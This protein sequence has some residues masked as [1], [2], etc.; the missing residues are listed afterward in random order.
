MTN[1][2]T[3]NPATPAELF[4]R[5]YAQLK[6]VASEQMK[7]ERAGHTLQA[8][9]LVNEAYLR[10]SGPGAPP[11]SSRAAFFH[12]AAEAMRRILIEHARSRGAAKRG[13]GARR[14]PADVLDLAAEQDPEQIVSFDAA[15]SRLEKQEPVAAAVV[16]LRFFAGLDLEATASA[17]GVST[18]TVNREWAFARAWLFRE[19]EREQSDGMTR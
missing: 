7:Q 10:L 4:E 5:V 16:R 14:L 13:G 3:P 11:M 15:I 9:A 6:A 1:A 8:T 19:L 18:R 12:A 17:L 2:E